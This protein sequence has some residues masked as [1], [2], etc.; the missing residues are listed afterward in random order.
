MRFCGSWGYQI[1]TF[2]LEWGML[3]QFSSVTQSCP[4]LCDPM[5][6]STPGLPVHHQLLEF[7]QTH[8]HRLSDAIQPPHPLSSLL[9]P[10][11]IGIPS[12]PWL[13]AVWTYPLRLGEGDGSWHLFPTNRKRGT[14]KGFHAQEPHLDLLGFKTRH[15]FWKASD[16]VS[17]YKLQEKHRICSKRIKGTK[18]Q[19]RGL[20]PYTLWVKQVQK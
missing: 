4:T 3:H 10:P 17:K 5:D 12:L 9:L 1:L 6:C 2:S 19:D 18:L 20:P 7:T 14:Q 11:S 16:D 15:G 8:V 13:A